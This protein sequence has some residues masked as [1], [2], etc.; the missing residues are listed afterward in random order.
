MAV[1]RTDAGMQQLIN[2]FGDCTKIE[3]VWENASP[4][5]VFAAQTIKKSLAAYNL[6][7]IITVDRYSIITGKN[8]RGSVYRNMSLLGLARNF[9]FTDSD[10]QIGV[11]EVISS[12]SGGWKT[13]NAYLKPLYIFGVKGVK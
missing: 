11:G 7:L 13:D 4:A 3:K 10:I 6:F 2:M 12:N 5:S 8:E 9:A 1:N